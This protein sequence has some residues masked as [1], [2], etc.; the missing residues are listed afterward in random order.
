L[1]NIKEVGLFTSDSV[2]NRSCIRHLLL[3]VESIP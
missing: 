1:D 3:S 2:N